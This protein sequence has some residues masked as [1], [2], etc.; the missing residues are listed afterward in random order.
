MTA[1]K[2]P[3]PALYVSRLVHDGDRPISPG[4]AAKIAESFLTRLKNRVRDSRRSEV[5]TP[6]K[7]AEEVS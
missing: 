6:R 1:V 5:K 2:K 7:S 4:D 3:D